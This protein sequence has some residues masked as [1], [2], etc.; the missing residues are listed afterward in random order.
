M[1]LLFLG[2]NWGLTVVSVPDPKPT[3]V[4][5]AFS[6]TH[7]QFQIAQVS[8]FLPNCYRGLYTLWSTLLSCF[9]IRMLQSY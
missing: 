1:V 7:G 6:I 5:M 2:F 3:P 9:G 4:Q 8:C